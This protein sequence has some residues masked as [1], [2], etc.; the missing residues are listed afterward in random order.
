M[1]LDTLLEADETL[2][3]LSFSFVCAYA[4]LETTLIIF[5]DDNDDHQH[6][7]IEDVLW[8]NATYVINRVASKGHG[9]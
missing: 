3:F 7:L 9:N 8:S 2:E 1:S 6:S 5:R 4:Y